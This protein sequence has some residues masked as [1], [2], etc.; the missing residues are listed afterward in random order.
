[1]ALEFASP[2]LQADREIVLEAVNEKGWALEY[3]S[4]QLQA[5]KDVLLAADT[6]NKSKSMN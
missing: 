3:A 1:M 2:Q 4:P 5:D 6:Q